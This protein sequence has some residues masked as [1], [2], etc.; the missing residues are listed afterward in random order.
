M[1]TIG[2]KF[3]VVIVQY[4]IKKAAV[5]CY[6]KI[7]KCRII[8]RGGGGVS[9]L[10]NRKNYHKRYCMCVLFDRCDGR[11]SSVQLGNASAPVKP[12]S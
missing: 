11:V 8:Q 4:V 9:K 1:C 7:F 10:I 6:S 2:K 5:T 12:A 3:H